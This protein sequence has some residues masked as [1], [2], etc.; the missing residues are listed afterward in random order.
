MLEQWYMKK[1]FKKPE[2]IDNFV[3]E[4]QVKDEDLKKNNFKTRSIRESK[5]RNKKI[6]IRIKT[7]SGHR[8]FKSTKL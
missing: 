6:W 2:K 5:R 1:V 7:K 3:E 4:L 8:N